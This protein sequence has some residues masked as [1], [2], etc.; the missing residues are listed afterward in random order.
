MSLFATPFDAT[1]IE[2]ENTDFSPLAPGK[3]DA[4]ISAAAEKSTKAGTG[5]YLS[6]EFT[7]TS[8]QNE[9]RRVWLNLNLVN[10]NPIAVEIAQKELASLCK[11][12]GVMQVSDE[13]QLVD[14]ALTIK[15]V[16]E[17]EGEGGRN[18]VKGFFPLVARVA[19]PAQAAPAAAPAASDEPK[20]MPWG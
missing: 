15:V 11:A 9:G 1:K 12:I 18:N 5:K 8:V 20:E 14:K 10:P 17:G 16:V 4:I 19:A 2:V 6:V 3:Y 7:V 13:S